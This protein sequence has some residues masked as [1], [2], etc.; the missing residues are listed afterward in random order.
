MPISFRRVPTH[1]LFLLIQGPSYCN[2]II[3]ITSSHFSSFSSLLFSSGVSCFLFICFAIHLFTPTSTYLTYLTYLPEPT[4][5]CIGQHVGP[6]PFLYNLLYL[7]PALSKATCRQTRL[8]GT[9]VILDIQFPRAHL[10]ALS[11]SPHSSGIKRDLSSTHTSEAVSSQRPHTSAPSAPV[12]V[13]HSSDTKKGYS[14]HK[15]SPSRV[16]QLS[17][18]MDIY[19]PREA[20]FRILFSHQYLPLILPR[21]LQ[22][23]FMI[24]RD[25]A[26]PN[27][28]RGAYDTTGVPKPKP[29]PPK[30]G[31]Q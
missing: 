9:T 15:H 4:S 19:Q 25:I 2:I 26:L 27:M 7:S 30:R 31:Q 29:P 13:N 16:S 6:I 22:N 18:S 11:P 17:L 24:F 21:L 3:I 1:F 28:G 12:V 14:R 8:S 20:V 10:I 23:L 5:A